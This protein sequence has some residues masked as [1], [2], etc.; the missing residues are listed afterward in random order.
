[1]QDLIN[2]AKKAAFTAGEEILAIKHPLITLKIDGSPVSSADLKASEIICEILSESKI[3][4]CSEEKILSYEKRQKAPFWLIDPI[5]GTSNYLK[6]RSNFCIC[7]S[8]IDG[9]RPILGLIYDVCNNNFYYSAKGMLVYKN[10][11]ILGKNKLES[12]KALISLRKSE[13]PLNKEI[14]FKYNYEPLNVG[15]ALKFCALLEGEADVYLRYEVLNSWD[16]A[17]GDFLINQSGGLMI[18][19]DKQKI[20]YNMVDFSTKPFIALSNVF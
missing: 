14:P 13:N 11:D 18:G 1:M 10:H 7:I 3:D 20:N 5:D 8:L 6:T 9:T 19:L 15:S 2:L 12:N 16:L 17:A 4:I